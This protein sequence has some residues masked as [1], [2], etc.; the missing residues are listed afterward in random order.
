MTVDWPPEYFI[1]LVHELCR[2]AG[3]TEWVEFRVNIRQ[4]EESGEFI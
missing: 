3:E 2:L 1:S 4:P